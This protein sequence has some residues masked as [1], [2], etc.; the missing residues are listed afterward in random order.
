M[1]YKQFSEIMESI[2]PE[3]V[4]KFDYWLATLSQ[5]DQKNIS[6]SVVSSRFGVHYSLAEH[7]LNYAASQKILGKVYILRCPKCDN[8][9]ARV[10]EQELRDILSSPAIF[11]SEC[12]LDRIITLENIFTAYEVISHPDITEEKLKVE[13]EKR[14]SSSKG[15]TQNFTEADS[16]ANNP[17]KVCQ[18]FYNPS[19]SAYEEFI[20]L[21]EKLDLDYGNDTTA[22][23]D[24]LE[25]LILS[26]FNS[27]GSVSGSNKIRSKTNQFDCTLLNNLKYGFPSV[28]DYLAPYFIIECKNEPNKKPDNNYMNK[29]QSIM[30]TNDA[31]LGIIFGRKDA[32]STCFSTSREHYLLHKNSSNRKVIITCCDIDLDYIIDKRVNLLEYLHFK[33]M[34]ITANTPKST[35]EMFQGNVEFSENRSA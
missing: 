5:N 24:A 22:K 3:F 30:E 7:I 32:T 21:R 12:E 19:E 1:F 6:A 28:F 9:L 18:I 20:H 29:L 8:F 16:L 13:I 23:G 34:Q 15:I 2:N 33:V 10:E 26:I 35:F 14:I 27:I 11:C 17:D 31:Q 25:T 4:E